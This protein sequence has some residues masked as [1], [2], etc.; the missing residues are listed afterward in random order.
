L[1]NPTQYRRVQQIQNAY[2]EH[3]DTAKVTYYQVNKATQERG[4]SCLGIDKAKF[5]THLGTACWNMSSTQNAAIALGCLIIS[6][7]II[8]VLKV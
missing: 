2:K 6:L 3:L 8:I 5:Q 7:Q 1:E 4:E